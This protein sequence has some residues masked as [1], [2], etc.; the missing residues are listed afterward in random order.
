M[1]AEI[2]TVPC[3]YCDQ[4]TAMLGTKECDPC[5]EVA[6]RLCSMPDEV[7]DRILSALGKS[8]LES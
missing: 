6:S 1:K 4:P 5:H 3:K 2:K 7:L 8:R